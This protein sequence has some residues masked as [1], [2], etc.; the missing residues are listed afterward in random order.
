MKIVDPSQVE[1]MKV[2]QELKHLSYKERESAEV[3]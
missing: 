1:A 2:V 3:V